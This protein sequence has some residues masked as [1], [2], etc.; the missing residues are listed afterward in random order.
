LAWKGIATLLIDLDPQGNAMSGFG[1]R[2]ESGGSLCYVLHSEA[3]AIDRAKETAQ[4]NLSIIP[5][6]VDLGAS[7]VEPMSCAEQ[8]KRTISRRLF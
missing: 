3:D 8:R 1:L 4:K 2:K 5:A 7:E 6:E